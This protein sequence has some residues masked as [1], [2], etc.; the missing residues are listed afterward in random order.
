MSKDSLIPNEMKKTAIRILKNIN[1]GRSGGMGQK[2][3]SAYIPS[4]MSSS[5]AMGYDLNE[6]L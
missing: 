3:K 6:I 2:I 4:I 5:S 1:G